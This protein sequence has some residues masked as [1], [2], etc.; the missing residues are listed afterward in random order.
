LTPDYS[1]PAEFGR[2]DVVVDG[3]RLNYWRYGQGRPL[4]V[5]HGV[6]GWGLDWARFA[7]RMGDAF[8]CI[9]LDQR[10][11]G[12]SDKPSDGYASA[13]LAADAW[14]VVERLALERPAVLGHSMGGG[15]ALALAA[16]HSQ[17]I[18]RLL[19][20]DPAVRLDPPG[21][22]TGPGDAPHPIPDVNQRRLALQ[23]RQ[24]LGRLTLTAQLTAA[25][26]TF[27]PEDVAHSVESTLLASPYVYSE[28]RRLDVGAQEGLLRRLACPTLVVRG[29]PA[30]GAVISDSTARRI[31]E[32]VPDDLARVTTIAGTGHVPQREAFDLFVAVVRPFLTGETVSPATGGSPVCFLH[33]LDQPVAPPGG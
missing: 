22:S 21:T 16:A 29:E 24:A 18:D 26:P 25:R 2:G 14:A 8:D 31:R 23:E 17:A 27:H 6:T 32:L 7:R 15:V 1:P 5:L 11:H 4:L 10:G 20:V 13:A 12:Y 33:L 3:V 30:R 28:A 9:L 19:L